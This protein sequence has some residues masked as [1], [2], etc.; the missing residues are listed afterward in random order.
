MTTYK[1]PVLAGA[2]ILVLAPLAFAHNTSGN[3]DPSNTSDKP[4]GVYVGAAGAYFENRATSTGQDT[5]DVVLAAG[6][7]LCDLEVL[8]DGSAPDA[9]LD[10]TDVDGTAGGSQADGSWDDGGFGAVCHVNTYGYDDDGNGPGTGYNTLGCEYTDAVG[11]D[12]VSDDVW[13]G[14]ACDYQTAVPSSDDPTLV[15]FVVGAAECVVNEVIQ[16]KDVVG[17]V[18]TFVE[19]LVCGLTGDDLSP[20]VPPSNCPAASGGYT[21]EPDGSADSG[22]FGLGSKGVAYPTTFANGCSATDGVAAT[23]VF[24][25]VVSG[26]QADLDGDSGHFVATHGWVN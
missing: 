11:A 9:T 6:N 10:E 4:A 2:M 3:Y 7:A 25:A 1:L 20:G 15:D 21:C 26:A 19:N 23:F 17:C 14:T 5:Q 18:T 16:D 13:L 12:D 22:N 8:G 24:D